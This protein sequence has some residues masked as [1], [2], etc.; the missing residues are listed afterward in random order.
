MKS[1]LPVLYHDK[2]IVELGNLP[3]LPKLQFILE[4]NKFKLQTSRKT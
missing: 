2:F 4:N 1:T 3:P